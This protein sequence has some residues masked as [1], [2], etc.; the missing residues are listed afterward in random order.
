MESKQRF[1]NLN[2]VKVIMSICIV[3]HHYQQY[4]GIRFSVVNFFD[5]KFFVGYLTEAFFMI[6]GFLVERT[7]I[8]A[9][10]TP[11]E[12]LKK[13]LIRIYPPA[14]I[15]MTAFLIPN[16][17]HRIVFHEWP[18]YAYSSPRQLLTS[19]LL[20]NQGWIAD[21]FPA[22][23]QPTWYLN[24]LVLC[25]GVYFVFDVISRKAN[26]NDMVFYFLCL[27]IIG[28]ACVGMGGI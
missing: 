2:L 7:R 21:L 14:W 16:Y 28:A 13:R 23:N 11:E 22:V 8:Q 10:R 15:A 5:G 17:I 1:E 12:Q 27:I 3:F 24:I 6:S 4:S 25:Y 26:K 20:I 9:D 18:V 19:Y